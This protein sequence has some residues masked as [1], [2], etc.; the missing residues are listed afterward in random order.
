MNRWSG[1]LAIARRRMLADCRR[2]VVVS[3]LSPVKPALGEMVI[4]LKENPA[5]FPGVGVTEIVAAGAASTRSSGS[6]SS[7]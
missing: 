7:R 1:T 2:D 5:E 6:T 3:G 4:G